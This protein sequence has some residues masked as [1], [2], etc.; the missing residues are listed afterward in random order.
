MS[1]LEHLKE[2]RKRLIIAGI[3]G[4]PGVAHHNAIPRTVFTEP[5]AFGVGLTPEQAERD[6][7]DL[8]TAHFNVGQTARA[9]VER[10]IGTHAADGRLELYADR[11]SSAYRSEEPANLVANVRTPSACPRQKSRRVSRYWSFHST[12]G[13]GIRPT[14]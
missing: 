12:H 9:Y 7:I 13:G 1:V 11:P 14:R 8:V 2:L 4:R 10:E 6:G 5:A 3:N